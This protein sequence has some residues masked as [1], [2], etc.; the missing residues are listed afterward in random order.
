VKRGRTEPMKKGDE[1]D[2]FTKWRHWL[3]VFHNNTGIA[4]YWKS[5]YNKRVRKDI[6]RKLRDQDET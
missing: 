5:A 3:C 2:A 4:K 6:K 1:V